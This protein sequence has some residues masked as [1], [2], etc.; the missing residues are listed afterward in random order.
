MKKRVKRKIKI[1]IFIPII[2]IFIIL[3]GVLSF[4]LIS[5]NNKNSLK[6]IKKN[7]NQYVKTTKNTTLY[8]KHHKKIGS[9]SKD[10]EL[11]LV[12]I[13]NLSN[14]NKYINIKDTDLYIYYNDITKIDKITK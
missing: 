9:I 10:Y 13:K 1:K 4:V 3:V 14:K 7:Y 5:I 6:V 12:K 11:E 2:I 8:D